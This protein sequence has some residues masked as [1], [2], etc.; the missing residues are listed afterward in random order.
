MSENIKLFFNEIENSDT[1]NAG[2]INDILKQLENE[3]L[4]TTNLFSELYYNEL[5]VK[6]LIKICNYYGLDK[7]TKG[8]KKND[9]IQLIIA[10][11]STP[12][13]YEYVERRQRFWTYMIEL[14]NDPI[15][16]K[17]IVWD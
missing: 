12:E 2:D 5:N 14:K 11:E 13:N 6:D 1:T 8:Y 16:K 17:Y 10:F 7:G 15:M 4:D 3:E 9:Y